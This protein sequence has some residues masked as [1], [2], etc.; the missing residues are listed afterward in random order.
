MFV[1]FILG[2][3]KPKQP[4]SKFAFKAS[5]VSTLMPKTGVLTKLVQKSQIWQLYLIYANKAYFHNTDSLRLLVCHFRDFIE[6]QRLG[7]CVID[8]IPLNAREH[9]FP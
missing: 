2:K 6:R 4:P 9:I 1:T 3:I 5:D 7:T 8:A